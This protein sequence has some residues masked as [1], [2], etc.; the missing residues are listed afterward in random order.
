MVMRW[1]SV[2][3]GEEDIVGES[4]SVR[5]TGEEVL[6]VRDT[7]AQVIKGRGT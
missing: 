3:E 4:K 5:G 2:A 6:K 7:G 1:I